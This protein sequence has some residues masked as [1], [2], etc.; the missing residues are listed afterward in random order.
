MLNNRLRSLAYNKNTQ[1]RSYLDSLFER[2]KDTIFSLMAKN[3]TKKDVS[4]FKPYWESKLQEGGEEIQKVEE[5][6]VEKK[7]SKKPEVPKLISAAPKPTEIRPVTATS[8]DV[9]L[10]HPLL[11]E[12]V[13][14]LGYKRLYLT[15]VQG[16]ART[17]VWKKQRILRP[18]RAALIADDKIRK[19][20]KSTLSGVISLYQD[21]ETREFGIIDGQHRAGALM[22]LAQRGYWDETKRNI[23]L[24]VFPTHGEDSVISLFREIN[25]AEPVRL[26]DLPEMANQDDESEDDDNSVS[27]LNIQFIVFLFLISFI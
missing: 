13:S 2:T 24:E 15:N 3:M 26:I 22:I 25:A 12:L 5:I 1:S 7:E 18:E 17:P 10:Y 11:G 9:F 8:S 27:I 4:K 6:K 21:K 16:L 19:G 14:D 23:L 20:F